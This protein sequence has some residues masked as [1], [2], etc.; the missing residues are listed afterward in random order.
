VCGIA[1]GLGNSDRTVTSGL[2]V[3]GLVVLSLDQEGVEDGALATIETKAA[4]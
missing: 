2:G 3:G 4:E 1:T